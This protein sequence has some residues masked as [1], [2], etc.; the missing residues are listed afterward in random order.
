MSFG[1]SCFA[2]ISLAILQKE[3]RDSVRAAFAEG[4]S[5]NLK[6][7]WK[8]YFLFCKFYGQKPIPTSTE[9]LCLYGQFLSRS[10]KS[11]ESIKNYIS[12]VKTLHYMLDIK[13]PLENKVQLDLM[14]RGL[15]RNNPHMPNRA[16]PMTPLILMDMHSFLNLENA[17]DITIWCVLLFMFFL[18]ARKS[19]MVPVSVS[20][21]DPDKQLLRQDIKV[22]PGFLVVLIKW[23]K[24][25]QFGSRLLKVPLVAIPGSD[26]CP[27]KA[28]KKMITLTPA[29]DHHPAFLI[30]YKKGKFRP[31]LYKQLQDK[32]KWLVTQTGR[33]PVQYSTHSLRR[34][35]CSFAFKSG[36]PTSLIQFHGDWASECYRNYLTFDFQEKL[37]VSEKM[38]FEI[39]SNGGRKRRTDNEF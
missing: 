7:Q 18:M 38:A 1:L 3:V 34:G 19:N 37:S 29:A 30:Q 27:V 16:L 28:Y 5:K 6:V 35:G 23:S 26:L 36:V 13:F 17:G 32:L 12:G 14:L 9:T 15:S 20:D 10:F 8:S 11:V 24:T 21:F 31:L 4:T 39:L 22:F 33:D 25:N 2:E